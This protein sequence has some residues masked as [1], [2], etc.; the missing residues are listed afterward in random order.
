MKLCPFRKYDYYQVNNNN[1]AIYS[2]SEEFLECVGK[3]CM[4]F[5]YPAFRISGEVEEELIRCKL[6]DKT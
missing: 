6:I 2:T 1:G 4:A 3:D 5:S